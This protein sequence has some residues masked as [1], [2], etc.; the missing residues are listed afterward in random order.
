MPDLEEAPVSTRRA[1]LG[2]LRL[3]GVRVEQPR[4]VYQRHLVVLV[5]A[6]DD[7]VPD[8]VRPGVPVGD[9]GGVRERGRRGVRDL[10]PGS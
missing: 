5:V 7:P 10:G 9:H 1:E 3:R 6:D 8:L 2:R 4:H